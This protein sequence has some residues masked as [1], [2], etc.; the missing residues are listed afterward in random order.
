[1][2]GGAVDWLRGGATQKQFDRFAAGLTDNL[3]R[4]AYLMTWDLHE[5]EDLVQETLLRVARRWG[6]IQAM[7]HPEAYA[8]RVLVNLVIDG[9]DRR[10]RRVEEL[11]D[12]QVLEHHVDDSAGRAV[13]GVDLAAEL[14]WA[15]AQLPRRQR[16][17]LVLRYW[18]DLPEAEVAE[19]L[20][21][22]V[23]TVKS[24]TSRGIARLRE[25]LSG[26]AGGPGP[27]PGSGLTSL[28]VPV[29]NT[30]RRSTSS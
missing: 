28:T 20:G 6:R 18:V 16:T 5:T 8:R 1:L 13:R 23:G 17:V 26:P 29:T 30:S 12:G 24:T 4:T 2:E 22:P 27:G 21:C 25:L 11:A 15:L 7:D 14:T 3:V 19:L 10:V 9:K